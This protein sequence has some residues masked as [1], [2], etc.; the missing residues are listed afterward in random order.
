MMLT[1]KVILTPMFVLPAKAG[2]GYF[3]YL[4]VPGFPLSRG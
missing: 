4:Q 3:R 2:S 1:Q